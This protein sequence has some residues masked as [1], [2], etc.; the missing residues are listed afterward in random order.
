MLVARSLMFV[1]LDVACCASIVGCRLLFCLLFVVC[2]SLFVVR[3][4]LVVGCW[5]SMII[6]CCLCCLSCV[7]CFVVC[8]FF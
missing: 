7:V 3:F 6:I 4:V 5:F 2:C 1:V 8:L